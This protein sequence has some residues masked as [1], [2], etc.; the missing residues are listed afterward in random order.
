MK[1]GFLT[2]LLLLGMLAPMTAAL[3]CPAE[4]IVTCVVS[5]VG[6]DGQD[7]YVRNVD[8]GVDVIDQQHPCTN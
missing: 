3:A 6:P 1:T 5:I 7:E 8:T 4:A 2:A